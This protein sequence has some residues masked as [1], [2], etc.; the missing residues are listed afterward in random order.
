MCVNQG[1]GKGRKRVAKEKGEARAK[2]IRCVPEKTCSTLN[3]FSYT[4]YPAK[5]LLDKI[6]HLSV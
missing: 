5:P 2:N 6:I 1:A 3:V 4:F